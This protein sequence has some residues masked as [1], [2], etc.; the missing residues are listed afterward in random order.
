MVAAYHSLVG[1]AATVTSIANMMALA[2]QGHSADGVHAVTAVLG[3]VIGAITL[4]GSVGATAWD[5]G[6][7]PLCSPPPTL[8]PPPLTWARSVPA[9]PG[10]G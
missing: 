6:A 4:T 8:C 9:V 5:A 3:D 7:N 2:D 10:Y 1:L